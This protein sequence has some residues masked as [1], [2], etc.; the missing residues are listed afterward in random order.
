MSWSLQSGSTT[1]SLADLH[2]I[3]GQLALA[4][5]AVETLTLTCKQYHC[6]TVSPAWSYRDKVTL[7]YGSDV[8][9]IGWCTGREPSGSGKEEAFNYTFSGPSWW[10]ANTPYIQPTVVTGYTITRGEIDS[11]G[12]GDFFDASFSINFAPSA[13]T[14]QGQIS[15]AMA[16]A[17][18]AG[19][20]L[21]PAWSVLTGPAPTLSA[22]NRSCLDV[23]R[24]ALRYR[25]GAC[26]HWDYSGSLP[27]LVLSHRNNTTPTTL[28]IG[29]DPI[30]SLALNPRDDLVIHRVRLEITHPNALGAEV[31]D[32][33]AAGDGSWP[34]GPGAIF[35]SAKVDTL[36]AEQSM[37][38]TQIANRIYGDLSVLGWEGQITLRD[39]SALPF[40]TPGNLLQVAS[41]HS[42]WAT[43]SA[44]VQ[45]VTFPLDATRRDACQ[46]RFG[47][48]E[49]LAIQD[50]LQSTA[51][52]GAIVSSIAG[53]N[54]AP[55][56]P[57]YSDLDPVAP[58]TVPDPTDPT[59]IKISGK[60]QYR[61]LEADYTLHGWAELTS[62]SS[63]P[64]YYRR[65]KET[66]SVTT[67]YGSDGTGVSDYGIFPGG[68]FSAYET[69]NLDNT[70]T[71]HPG[72]WYRGS[73][74][75]RVAGIFILT[76]MYYIGL[77]VPSGNKTTTP[78]V[79]HESTPTTPYTTGGEVWQFGVSGFYQLEYSQED[80]EDDG[81]A[82]SLDGQ[83]W[84]SWGSAGVSALYQLRTGQTGV[85]RRVQ[86][87]AAMMG[88]TAGSF[89][90]VVQYEHR[91]YGSS[92]AFSDS[93]SITLTA[94]S[95]SFGNFE[96][97]ETEIPCDLGYET[98]VKT[99]VA[100]QV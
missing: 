92:G 52:A 38:T 75:S 6:A 65:R 85:K 61:Y 32:I 94:S 78:T 44:Q 37:I 20:P 64:K 86:F 91:L 42:A 97:S 13:A 24:N 2:V 83:D 73:G 25:P 23:L 12:Y 74:G 34:L 30:E 98:R 84:S 79:Y 28:T 58:S 5:V 39:I 21:S 81:I 57:T 17:I 35:A 15:R 72:T 62:P 47:P 54:S 16:C 26:A 87:R 70:Q 96:V 8:K 50:Y 55:T 29:T 33:D 3:G 31:T 4:S 49:H 89:S 19:A 80:T 95:D 71:Y 56:P 100:T 22:S 40:F 53:N 88:R 51:M 11:G 99:L 41:G 48:P 9:F 77:N 43:M 18:Q 67:A 90:I 69:Y 1:Y 46:I 66:G 27:A 68:V 10:L 45:T 36:A 82:R 63:P 60:I 7:R 76:G 59:K 14:V 93:T